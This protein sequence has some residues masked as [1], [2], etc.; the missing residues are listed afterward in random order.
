MNLKHYVRSVADFPKP[1]I[2]FRDITPLLKSP[3]AMNAVIQQLAA[4]FRDSGINTIIAAEA[5]GFMFGAPLAMELGAGFVPVRKPGKLPWKT[6]RFSY[7]LEY[8][9]DSLEIHTDAVVMVIA[10]CWS[11]TCWQQANCRSLPE[12]GSTTTSG[13]CGSSIRDRIVLPEGTATTSRDQR[14]EPD[15]VPHRRSRRIV[16]AN[17]PCS[18]IIAAAK[19]R[20]RMEDKLRE[21]SDLALSLAQSA[22][23]RVSEYVCPER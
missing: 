2:M 4:P 21:Y 22:T 23:D 5:R 16:E 6:K 8:G 11:M 1:G 15:H 13:S 20:R 12:A 14:P 3:E 9:S 10:C 7:D 18:I 17:I 19:D